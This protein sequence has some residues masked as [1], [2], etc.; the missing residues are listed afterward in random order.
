MS[1]RHFGIYVHIPFCVSKCAY[2]DFYSLPCAE[3]N[4]TDDAKRSYVSALIRHME[5]VSKEHENAVA[6]TVFVGGGTP[7]LL[8]NDA[9][10]EL[11]GA[12]K[13]CFDLSELK[14]FTF[15]ANPA[16]FD[17]EK[18]NVMRECGCDRLSIGMQSA[19]ENELK[20]LSRIHTF[21]DVKSSVEL[22]RKCGFENINLDLMYGIPYQTV[23]SFKATLDLAVS[24][25]PEHLSVYGLQK[26]EGTPMY[27]NRDSY[28]FPS[29][30]EEYE[31]TLL[32]SEKLKNSGYERYEISNYSKPGRQCL[33]NL[34]YW[35]RGE[36]LGFGCGAHS[37]A[38]G[39]RY[40]CQ[41]DLAAYTALADPTE[42]TVTDEV[43]T[44]EDAVREY[45]MLGLRLTRGVSL[46]HLRS[47]T[48][49]AEDHIKRAERF[50]SAGLMRIK[51][52]YLSFTDEGF[53][54]S[55]GIISEIIY[56]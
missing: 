12:I 32:L 51:D 11:A 6:D 20:A 2:C 41:K 25:A 37:F 39:R 7:T 13:R 23:S 14:E 43:L 5:K 34:G 44:E 36:Y 1:A 52:G 10:C 16:T 17:G 4:I 55:N 50:V 33:H 30:D 18:L 8:P 9:I 48:D 35:T 56:G 45:I 3:R 15:E 38:N 26:E 54:V 24:L 40:H 46:E 42:L 22:A 19:N 29:E 21:S 53:N 28:V 49:D 27:E 31:M 47:R